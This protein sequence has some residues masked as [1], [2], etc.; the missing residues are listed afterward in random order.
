MNY[1][2]IET[3]AYEQL[4]ARIGKLTSQVTALAGRLG[5]GPPIR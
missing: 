2:L 1:I 5:Y 3:A 4:V